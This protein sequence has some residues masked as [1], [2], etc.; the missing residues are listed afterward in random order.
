VTKRPD[1]LAQAVAIRDLAL[2]L[3][4]DAGLREGRLTVWRQNDDLKRGLA[5][6]LHTP[7]GGIVF[8]KLEP[9]VQRVEVDGLKLLTVKTVDDARANQPWGLSIWSEGRKVFNIDWNERPQRIN[10]ITFRRGPWE[11]A[12]LELAA[13]R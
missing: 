7:F 3:L 2:R 13:K 5:L 1:R 10:V 6:S 4:R 12:L 8:P 11:Q 9:D